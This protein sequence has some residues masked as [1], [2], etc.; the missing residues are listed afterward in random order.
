[1]NATV[2]DNFSECARLANA[3][4][5]FIS[6]DSLAIE[7]HPQRLQSQERTHVYKCAKTDKKANLV[8]RIDKKGDF[9]V[10]NGNRSIS[11]KKSKNSWALTIKT[12]MN[13]QKQK[14][15]PS[16]NLLAIEQQDVNYS[17]LLTQFPLYVINTSKKVTQLVF[18]RP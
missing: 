1:M 15:V 11:A 9:S 12:S 7:E 8:L 6:L 5:K 4:E 18:I 10:K 17:G 3:L 13:T 2:A 16:A 14:L